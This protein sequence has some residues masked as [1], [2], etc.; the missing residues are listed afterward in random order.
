MAPPPNLDE[1]LAADGYPGID[2]DEWPIIRD[3]LRDYGRTYDRLELNV[4]LGEGR[5]TSPDD[6]PSIKRMWKAVTQVRADL[7]AWRG[8]DADVVEAKVEARL[9]AA[10]QVRKYAAL[11]RAEADP[12][13]RVTPIVICRRGS[14]AVEASMHV[15][16]G[17]M[18]RVPAT[19]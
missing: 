18:Q 7:I 11:L 5:P 1:L 14:I 6:S 13:G 3:W 16:G 8:H 10:T 17:R 15:S 4:R 12:I 2:A 9:D 19:A